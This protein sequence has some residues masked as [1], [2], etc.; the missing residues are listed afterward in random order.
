MPLTLK[1]SKQAAALVCS[2]AKQ[3]ILFP[4]TRPQGCT[5]AFK[6]VLGQGTHGHSL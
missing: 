1:F 2:P 4:V 3:K 5:R 6:I